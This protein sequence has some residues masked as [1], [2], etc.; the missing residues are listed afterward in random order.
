MKAHSDNGAITVLLQDDVPGLQVLRDGEWF[1]VQPLPGVLLVNLGDMLQVNFPYL[2]HSIS[3]AN[4]G[5]FI[6]L[7][8]HPAKHF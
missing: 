6:A 8:P 2:L 4:P 3:E 1:T 5:V 7:Q